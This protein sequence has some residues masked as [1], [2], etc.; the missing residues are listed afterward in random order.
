M[1][2]PQ[3]NS[4]QRPC[5][6]RW[7][8]P[9]ASRDL[10]GEQQQHRSRRQRQWS[11]R[12]S[13]RSRK[14]IIR[15]SH[16]ISICLF[17]AQRRSRGTSLSVRLELFAEAALHPPAGPSLNPAAAAATLTQIW[18]TQQISSCTHVR[19]PS[20]DGR[21]M[22]PPL[23]CCGSWPPR[24]VSPARLLHHGRPALCRG[25]DP[26]RDLRKCGSGHVQLYDAA[27]G[28]RGA[29]GRAAVSRG[30]PAGWRRSSQRH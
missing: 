23:P 12:S 27:Q 17:T 18:T 4:S 16:P 20:P 21:Y 15:H 3:L 30:W 19:P 1:Q 13:N 28:H 14:I 10:Q 26:G 5:P 29:R 25:R 6:C 7:Q 2:R 22:A 11:L 8:P 9:L 24:C